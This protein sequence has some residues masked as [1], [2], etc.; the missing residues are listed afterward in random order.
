[1]SLNKINH[2]NTQIE[3]IAV[4]FFL[5]KSQSRLDRV[6]SGYSLG[7]V[8][9]KHKQD[10]RRQLATMESQLKRIKEVNEKDYG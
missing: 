10:S 3:S 6:R 5:N 1:M 9:K 2:E 8:V 4:K 7:S